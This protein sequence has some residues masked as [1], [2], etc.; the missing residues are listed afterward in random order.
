MKKNR[1]EKKSKSREVDTNAKL[2]RFLLVCEGEETE[3]NYFEA[4]KNTLPTNMIK[5]D[6]HG[7]GKNTL[8]L[9]NCAIKKR[10]TDV[11]KWV[12]FDKD[13]CPDKDFNAAIKLAEKNDIKCAWS[14][15]AFELWFIL[16]FEDFASGLHRNTYKEKISSSLKKY[17][18]KFKYEKNMNMYE[19]LQKYGDE[20]K[21]ITRAKKLR[22]KQENKNYATHNPCT[23]VDILVET[24]NQYKK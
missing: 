20:K 10:I 13:D 24:L 12:I 5:I 14:N 4:L 1:F 16:H 15:Q 2:R 9:V 19:L 22:E 17:D 21:A 23:T 3:P 7:E 18:N 8:A 6:I 11:E